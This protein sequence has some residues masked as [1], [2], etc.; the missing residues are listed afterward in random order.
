MLVT[1]FVLS[2]SADG[3]T[4]LCLL[5]AVTLFDIINDI[6]NNDLHY[7]GGKHMVKANRE[8]SQENKSS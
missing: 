3:N 1:I 6:I 5:S 8:R 2:L 4:L 7:Y